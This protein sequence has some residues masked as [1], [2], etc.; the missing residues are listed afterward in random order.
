M[1]G[2]KQLE[3]KK[4]YV[5]TNSNRKYQGI[6]KEVSDADAVNRFIYLKDKYNEI[7]IISISDI[8]LI[9]EESK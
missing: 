2:W 4:V 9:Q 7:I 6:V 8:K 1:D 5:E 3:G